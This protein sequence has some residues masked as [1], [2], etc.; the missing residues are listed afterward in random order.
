MAPPRKDQHPQR[1]DQQRQN[2][3]TGQGSNHA[4]PPSWPN[5]NPTFPPPNPAHT[6]PIST[7]LP[8]GQLGLS[9]QGWYPGTAPDGRRFIYMY[10]PPPEWQLPSLPC[11]FLDPHPL[12]HP[13]AQPQ[14]QQPFRPIAGAP[15][16]VGGAGGL[17]N[18]DGRPS[19]HEWHQTGHTGPAL[20]TPAAPVLNPAPTSSTSSGHQQQA[21]NLQSRGVVTDSTGKAYDAFFEGIKDWRNAGQ[22]F[23]FLLRR[24]KAC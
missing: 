23:T 8:S 17:L 16:Q 5:P 9:P 24:R 1:D 20:S 10:P 11:Y 3:G 22:S 21:G 2:N 4:G 15:P 7:A 6:V 19:S 18:A 12:Q 13:P 14:Q